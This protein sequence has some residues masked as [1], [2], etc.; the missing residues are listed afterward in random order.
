MQHLPLWFPGAGFKR[1]AMVWKAK[2][3]EFVDRPYELVKER[4]VRLI[5][6]GRW[7]RLTY[8]SSAMALRYHA[9]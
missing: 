2:M 3:E 6:A 5:H 4:M 7:H 8:A 1:K 9:S